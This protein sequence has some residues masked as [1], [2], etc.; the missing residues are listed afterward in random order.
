MN[1]KLPVSVCFMIC[2]NR[3]I[4]IPNVLQPLLLIMLKNFCP[5]IEINIKCFNITYSESAVLGRP[6]SEILAPEGFPLCRTAFLHAFRVSH[7]AQALTQSCYPPPPA[8]FQDRSHSIC[9]PATQ[10]GNWHHYQAQWAKISNKKYNIWI[11]VQLV[12]GPSLP[13]SGLNLGF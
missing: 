3:K 11:I 1:W 10:F 4:L 12:I 8:I 13:G 6:W 9:S 7:W 2:C 5:K